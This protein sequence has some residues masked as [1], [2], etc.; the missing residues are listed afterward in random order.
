[1]QALAFDLGASGGKAF[2]GKLKSGKL[3]ISEVHRFSNDPVKIG[4]RFYWDIL[5]LY[6]EI[7]QGLLRA[8]LEDSEVL[9]SI[10][11][12]TWGLDFGLIDRNGHLLANPSHYRDKQSLGMI[13]KVCSIIPKEEMYKKTGIQFTPVNGL[14]HLFAMK[15]EVNPI[16]QVTDTFLMIPDLLRYFLTGEKTVEGTIASTSQLFNSREWEHTIIQKLGFPSHWFPPIVDAGSP[17]GTIRQSIADELAIPKTEVVAVAEHDTASAVISVPTAEENFAYLSCGTWSLLGTELKEPII[18]QQ[19]ME[20]NFTNETGANGTTRL[21]KNIMGLWLIQE[22]RRTWEKEGQLLS[23]EEMINLANQASPFTAFINPDHEM[24][25]NP[26]KMPGQIQHYCSITKQR[27]PETKGEIVRT[28]LEGLALKYRF[29]LDRIEE[30]TQVKYPCLH[31]VGGGVQ[32][33]LL[34]QF[35]ANALSRHVWAGPKEATA[36]GNLL[37]QY[38]A[39]REIKDLREARDIV[40]N[41]FSINVYE[42]QESLSWQEAF[43]QFKEI[44]GREEPLLSD[45]YV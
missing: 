6:H 19:S 12:D 39:K 18:N 3:I 11:I 13:E 28:I 34:C 30:L 24:F 10:G 4:E 27:I 31:I 5:R 2:I 45:R 26:D 14:Y 37:M 40:K 33:Q 22:C 38:I 35:T 29:V 43:Q 36:I 25:L 20:W 44:M 9:S 23:F 42:P 7:K 32:N 15:E 41:S 16:L 17:A 8:K 1:M 21:L